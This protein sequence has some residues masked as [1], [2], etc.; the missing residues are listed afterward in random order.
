MSIDDLMIAIIIAGMGLTGAYLRA[1]FMS[2]RKSN[3]AERRKR[4]GLR[5]GRADTSLRGSAIPDFPV[6]IE[7]RSAGAGG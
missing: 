2:W 5:T 4:A 6:S 7:R 3:A 1:E